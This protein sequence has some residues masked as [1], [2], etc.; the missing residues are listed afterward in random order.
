MSSEESIRI[1]QESAD[2]PLQVEVG[3]TRYVFPTPVDVQA[4]RRLQA[5]A[6]TLL[7]WTQSSAEAGSPTQEPVESAPLAESARDSAEEDDEP[8]QTSAPPLPPPHFEP[9]QVATPAL[10][11]EITEPLWRRLL[12]A[13]LMRDQPL[14]VRSSLDTELIE[15][16]E[17]FISEL[18]SILSERLAR[19]GEP[20]GHEVRLVAGLKGQLQIVVNGDAYESV[21]D[22]P[23]AEVQKVLRETISEWES[24]Y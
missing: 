2:E 9:S 10:A 3:I 14:P 7:E 12:D 19:R 8:G 24:R 11:E 13:I 6:T 5:I 20:L 22:V 23:E 21:E 1:T 16:G 4:A 15:A 17:S 18:E